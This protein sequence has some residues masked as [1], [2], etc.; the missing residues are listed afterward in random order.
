MG[1]DTRTFL[2]SISSSPSS[3]PLSPLP[4]L[5]LFLPSISFLPSLSLVPSPHSF[6]R[7]QCLSSSGLALLTRK[8]VRKDSLTCTPAGTT[9]PLPHLPPPI[10][11]HSQSL[12]F[13]R[14]QPVRLTHTP[15]VQVCQFI[16]SS[17][18]HY[19]ILERVLSLSRHLG[20]APSLIGQ[21]DLPEE[22]W[23]SV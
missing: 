2:I 18:M 19:R 15:P 16:E 7:M 14:A 11:P 21:W 13:L 1:C 20:A 6:L 17:S 8:P 22:T 10:P 3:F 9:S 23:V 4:P 5:S 12:T